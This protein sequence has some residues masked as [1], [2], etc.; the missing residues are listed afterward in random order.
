LIPLVPAEKPV[1][2]LEIYGLQ[3]FSSPFITDEA[4]NESVRCFIDFLMV[5]NYIW[6]AFFAIG[7][8]TALVRLVAGDTS[9]FPAMVT[10]LHDLADTAVTL[11][12]GYIGVMSLWLGIMKI[13]ERGGAVGVL[14]KWL[15]PFFAHLFPGIPA[16]HPVTGSM[17]MNFA[18][19]MLGL[20]NSATPL[21]LKAM[22]ELQELNPD[23]DTA[24]NAQ[25]MFLVLN[26]SGLTIIPVSVI[27]LRVAKGAA[28]PTDVF[29]PILIATFV[30][31]LVGLTTVALFQR[32][33]LFKPV[34][35]AYLGGATALVAS[36]IWYF[37][38]LDAAWA[39]TR[40]KL[41]AELATIHDAITT[42]GTTATAEQ[43]SRI[44]GI[45]NLIPGPMA[46]Q[47]EFL[48]AFIIFAIIMGFLA[49]AVYRRVNV[50]ESF[51]EGAKEGFGVA[52]KII[53]YLVAMLV[54]IGVFRASGAMNYLI[55]GVRTLFAGF[56]DTR[57]VEA[58]P[59]AL[60]KPLSG[61]GARGA[62][63]DAMVTFGPDSFIGTLAST[64]QGST[65]TT[66]YTLA[67][68]FGAVGVSRTRYTVVAGLI[69]DVAGIT[70]AIVVAYL[71]FGD[72]P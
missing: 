48:G 54:A 51:V 19:N 36:M 17:V 68:Y 29:I 52:I 44:E 15:A 8:V 30:S 63:A 3:I 46:D 10:S 38:N 20:D 43:T 60:M 61:S 49:L 33:N 1:G 4:V 35:L 69:A 45:K 16:G 53:P 56:G 7:F 59:T 72:R 55:D 50:Y 65:E 25:I 70:A 37:K 34:V 2:E 9:V 5:L 24:S 18:A 58:L 41:N 62:A 6:L 31:T 23:K 64:M 66:F 42:A 14:T 71:F 47:S 11:A 57:W 28:T 39:P 27:A 12:L 26:T 32:I 40:D 21:G 22:N 13:G 67:V